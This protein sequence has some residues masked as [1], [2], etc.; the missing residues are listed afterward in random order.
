MVRSLQ[1]FASTQS[2]A[3]TV[4][5]RNIKPTRS[6]ALEAHRCTTGATHSNFIDSDDPELVVGEGGEMQNDRVE[7]PGVR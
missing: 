5:V 6:A 3:A 2:V 1:L 4:H 7:G